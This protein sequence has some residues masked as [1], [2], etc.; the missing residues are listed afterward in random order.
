MFPPAAA[1]ALAM[2]AA[3]FCFAARGFAT[4]RGLNASNV[5]G[6][7]L[8]LLTSLRLPLPS[9]GVNVVVVDT[10]D[11]VTAS[12]APPP[13]ADVAVSAPDV[14][15]ERCSSGV[16]RRGGLLMATLI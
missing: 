3:A 5:R 9:V 11:D 10:E 13:R 1:A 4:A 12:D 14:A 8:R 15:V 16:R 6:F 7:S 2:K